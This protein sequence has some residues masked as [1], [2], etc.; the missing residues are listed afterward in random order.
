MQKEILGASSQIAQIELSVKTVKE[1]SEIMTARVS[2]I[3]AKLIANQVT[4]QWSQE[5]IQAMRASIFKV[6]ICCKV[7]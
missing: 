3:D 2:G 1:E 7:F 4:A 5:Q 6:Q